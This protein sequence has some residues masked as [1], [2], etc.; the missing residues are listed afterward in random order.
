[1]QHSLLHQREF[2]NWSSDSDHSKQT[3][4]VKTTSHWTDWS[5][6]LALCWDSSGDTGAGCGE[7]DAASVKHHSEH[8]G[9]LP[10]SAGQT[11]EHF[12]SDFFSSD[13]TKNV[14]GSHSY[15][16][17]SVAAEFKDI[18]LQPHQP[19]MDILGLNEGNGGYWLR[20]GKPCQEND[21]NLIGAWILITDDT[22]NNNM[23]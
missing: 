12:Q 13:V 20:P 6:R 19:Q 5:G 9:S 7:E 15:Q 18:I 17:P 8:L 21:V 1:M 3:I 16:L 2:I 23:M 10:W 14:T 22:L 11:E 4:S